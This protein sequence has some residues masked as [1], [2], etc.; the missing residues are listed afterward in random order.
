MPHIDQMAAAAIIVAASF[1]LVAVFFVIR[2]ERREAA[3]AQESP[4]AASTEGEKRC[5]KCGMG[6]LWTDGRCV[7]CGAP[8]SG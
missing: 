1:G 2:R 8:L 7:S 6:N 5:A 3:A 4:F